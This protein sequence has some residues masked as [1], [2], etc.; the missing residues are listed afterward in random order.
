MAN[1]ENDIIKNETLVDDEKRPTTNGDN[2]SPQPEGS[3]EKDKQIETDQK[4]RK[5]G[6]PRKQKEE[7]PEEKP[8]EEPK[9]VDDIEEYLKTFN[10]VESEQGTLSADIEQPKPKKRRGR[11]PGSTKKRQQATP[12]TQQISG[13]MLLNLINLIVPIATTFLYGMVDERAKKVDPAN[14]KLD[15]GEKDELRESADH[16]AKE[17]IG[18]TNPI[19]IFGIGLLT[20]F[21]TK[22]QAEISTIPKTPKR[23]KK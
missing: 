14:L 12:E 15:K 22:L 9:K 20:I 21:A 17:V 10:K 8:K 3:P 11:P 13:E 2:P 5:R 4:P 19:W 7:K 23:V 16:V 6:R 1:N 18:D